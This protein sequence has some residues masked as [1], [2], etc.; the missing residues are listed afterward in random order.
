MTVLHSIRPEDITS[1]AAGARQLR[2]YLEYVRNPALAFEAELTGTGE[3]E[4]PFEEAVLAALQSRGHRVESQVGV[5]GYR[6]R[7]SRAFGGR[8]RLRPRHR[9]RRCDI[10]QLA[11]RTRP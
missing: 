8:R 5:S 3:P 6:D 9:V 4:S 10:P 2:R 7:L 11:G 1:T